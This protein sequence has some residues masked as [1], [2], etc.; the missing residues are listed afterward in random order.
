[1]GPKTSGRVQR[2]KTTAHQ[3][4]QQ[5]L[6]TGES[7][8]GSKTEQDTEQETERVHT[9]QSEKAEKKQTERVTQS[10]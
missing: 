2:K 6:R 10:T 7:K 5:R 3:R 4:P 9:N 1:L 8:R